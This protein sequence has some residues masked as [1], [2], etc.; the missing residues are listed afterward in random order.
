[1]KRTSSLLGIVLSFFVA[2]GYVFAAQGPVPTGDRPKT[3]SQ[4]VQILTAEMDAQSLD[5]IWLTPETEVVS[6][7]HFT[8]V[9]SH[10]A[11]G[12]VSEIPLPC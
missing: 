4:A 2:S 1:M 11:S 5:S 12:H 8:A 9:P 7:F 10:A 3:V 6:T